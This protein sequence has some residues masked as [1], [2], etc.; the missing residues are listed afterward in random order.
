MCLKNIEKKNKTK[1]KKE[2]E[3]IEVMTFDVS[4]CQYAIIFILYK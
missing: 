4:K 3:I 1:E 2:K